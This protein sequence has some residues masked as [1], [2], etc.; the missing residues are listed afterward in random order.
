[1]CGLSVCGSS[2]HLSLVYDCAACRDRLS[3]QDATVDG[4]WR[5][6]HDHGIG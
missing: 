5:Y 1:M 2:V 4:E 3:D 6:P